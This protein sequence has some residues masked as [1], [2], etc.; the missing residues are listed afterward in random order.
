MSIEEA[1][2][3]KR[4]GL[5]TVLRQT[6][7]TFVVLLHAEGECTVCSVIAHSIRIAKEKIENFIKN[8]VPFCQILKSFTGPV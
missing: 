1:S 8:T 7:R 4:P 5:E 2:A 6:H 3:G